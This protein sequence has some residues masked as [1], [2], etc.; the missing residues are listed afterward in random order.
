MNDCLYLLKAED[1]DAVL[2]GQDSDSD[3]ATPA[4][5]A[6]NFRWFHNERVPV[7]AALSPDRSHT[8]VDTVTHRV[9]ARC[10]ESDFDK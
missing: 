9:S 6:H 3:P 2:L 5:H 10:N 7:T 1:T 8:D 4:S